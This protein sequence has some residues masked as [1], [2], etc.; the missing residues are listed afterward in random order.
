MDHTISCLSSTAKICRRCIDTHI[1][2]I[3]NSSLTMYLH[4]Q[5]QYEIVLSQ[6]EESKK[7]GVVTFG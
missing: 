5:V 1:F 6:F 2:I 3:D 7:C 4:P